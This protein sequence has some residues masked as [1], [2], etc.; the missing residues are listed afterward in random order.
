MPDLADVVT[1]AKHSGF[2]WLAVDATAQNVTFCAI[3]SAQ[4]RGFLWATVEQWSNVPDRD[5]G[6]HA[7]TEAE[8]ERPTMR[9]FAREGSLEAAPEVSRLPVRYRP[10]RPLGSGWAG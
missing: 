6:E 5:Q 4:S 3:E 2:G 10:P 8:P 7:E 9:E 1:A